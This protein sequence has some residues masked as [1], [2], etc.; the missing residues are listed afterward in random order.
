MG[1][2]QGS[3][4]TTIQSSPVWSASYLF[5]DISKDHEACVGIYRSGKRRQDRMT[6]CEATEKGLIDVNSSHRL[7]SYW[8][9]THRLSSMLGSF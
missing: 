9:E 2:A 6:G 3:Q 4:D 8:E 5:H 1:H 7:V